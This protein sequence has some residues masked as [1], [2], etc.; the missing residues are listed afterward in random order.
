MVSDLR[1]KVTTEGTQ[2]AEIYD[3]FACF[4]KS[5]TDEKS[6]AIG[7]A[8]TSVDLLTTR[9]TNLQATRDQLDIDIQDLND[10]IS[11]F[12]N[13][14]TSAKEMRAQ[15][16]TTFEAGLADVT[17]AITQMEK[18]LDSIK[19]MKPSLT[20]SSLWCARACSWRTL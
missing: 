14:V 6:E 19:A 11:G 13:Q 1:A 10:Q 4:C 9:I 2:E 3:E 7:E 18:A 15:E 5:K 12:E 20:Q 8:E 17:H 16:T